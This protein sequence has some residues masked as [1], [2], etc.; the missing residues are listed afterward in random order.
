MEL[1]EVDEVNEGSGVK[2]GMASWQDGAR[3]HA[4]G[5]GEGM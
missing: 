3:A 2:C 5:E 1:C 4:F